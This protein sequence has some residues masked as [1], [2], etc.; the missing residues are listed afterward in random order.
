MAPHQ[1]LVSREQHDTDLDPG[2]EREERDPVAGRDPAGLQLSTSA[3]TW[4]VDAVFPYRST[5]MT[6]G[7]RGWPPSA[8]STTFMPLRMA[9]AEV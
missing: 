9:R 5:V 8:S 4:V 7:L 1:F 6:A 2:C 3:T